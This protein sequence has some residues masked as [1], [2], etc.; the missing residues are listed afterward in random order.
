MH[1]IDTLGRKKPHTDDTPLIGG[2][3]FVQSPVVSVSEE[4]HPRSAIRWY[5]DLDGTVRY[6]LPGDPAYPNSF[7]VTPEQH[8]LLVNQGYR[9][10]GNTVLVGVGADL[11]IR[12]SGIFVGDEVPGWMKWAIKIA[13]AVAM[14]QIAIAVGPLLVSITKNSGIAKALGDE[15]DRFKPTFNTIKDRIE[16]EQKRIEGL[17]DT[18][19]VRNSLSILRIAHTVGLK[20]SDQYAK[21][22]EDLYRDTRTLSRQVFGEANQI[23]SA[24]GLLR[25]SVADLTALKGDRVDVGDQRWFT[26][27]LRLTEYVEDNSSKYARRPETFW[28]DLNIRFIDPILAESRKENEQ[29]WVIVDNIRDGLNTAKIASNALTDRFEKYRNE[30]DTFLSRDNR[31]ALDAISRDFDRRIRLPLMAVSNVVQNQFPPLKAQVINNRTTTNQQ[32]EEIVIV[33]ERT[34]DPEEITEAQ[35]EQNRERI[36]RTLGSGPQAER[37]AGK[38]ER[39]LTEIRR[40]ERK[41]P[42]R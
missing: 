2:G 14:A 28:S 29:R 32:Q 3:E 17:L 23:A 36:S 31:Q 8:D 10:L 37:P 34:D 19:L 26:E 39:A 13:L 6:Y 1:L 22:I 33:T 16:T 21:F 12:S 30:V 7:E 11:V 27:S 35:A 15:L 9:S 25:L 20:T 40:I 18:S 24:L 4:T 38:I 41:L 42:R 5:P